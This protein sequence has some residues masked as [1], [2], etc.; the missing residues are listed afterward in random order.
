MKFRFSIF[1]VAVAFLFSS[2]MV[3]SALA[4]DKIVWKMASSWPKGTILQEIADDF[5]AQVTKMSDG[6]LTI[7]SYPAGVLM[8]ASGSDRSCTRM[9]TIDAAHSSP[10]YSVGQL[11]AA[12]LFGYIPFGMEVIPYLTWMYEGEGKALVNKAIREV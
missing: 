1:A 12:P 9:G 5:A 6:R 10:S 4:S 11:P 7:K 8:G 3:S 2:F